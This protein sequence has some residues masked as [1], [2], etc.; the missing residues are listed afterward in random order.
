MKLRPPPVPVAIATDDLKLI[1][2]T[3]EAFYHGL[4]ETPFCIQTVII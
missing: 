2:L 3:N 4:M 1:L